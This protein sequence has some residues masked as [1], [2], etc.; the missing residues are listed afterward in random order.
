VP[1]V[2]WFEWFLAAEWF[3][4]PALYR[5][6]PLAATIDH[7]SILQLTSNFGNLL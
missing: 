7:P 1:A 4:Q 2:E 5:T 3:T 6:V